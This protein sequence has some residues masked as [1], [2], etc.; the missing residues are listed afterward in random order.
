[1][2]DTSVPVEIIISSAVLDS[3][4]L[5]VPTNETDVEASLGKIPFFVDHCYDITTVS[6]HQKWLFS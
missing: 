1:V 6:L 5:A 4:T 3:E 2:F